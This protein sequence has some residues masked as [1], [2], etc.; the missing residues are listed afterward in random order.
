[1]LESSM[2]VFNLEK[3][4]ESKEQFYLLQIGIQRFFSPHCLHVAFSHFSGSEFLK[5]ESVV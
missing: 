4:C 3:W 1:M 5:V 2:V